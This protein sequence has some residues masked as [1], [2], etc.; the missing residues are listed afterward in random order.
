MGKSLFCN[1]HVYGVCMYMY[2]FTCRGTHLEASG[3]CWKSS[4]I[5]LLP[6]LWRQGLL[7]KP[8]V[9]LVASLQP[10]CTRGQSSLRFP[11]LALQVSLPLSWHSV[12][13]Q[14]LNSGPHACVARA[15]ATKPSSP[16]PEKPNSGL[17]YPAHIK[18]P[19]EYLCIQIKTLVQGPHIC[20]AN[21]SIKK[22]PFYSQRKQKRRRATHLILRQEPFSFLFF[23][24]SQTTN[25]F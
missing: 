12:C 7:I 6:Y 10:A 19:R 3:S 18:L 16:A 21:F 9:H 5:T 11:R 13:S 20:F 22:N 4:L 8:R 15:L 17:T 14:D 25:S 24:I 23:F 1:F 2:V